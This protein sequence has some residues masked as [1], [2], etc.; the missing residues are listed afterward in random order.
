MIAPQDAGAVGLAPFPAAA[1]LQP[2]TESEFRLIRDFVHREAGIFLGPHKMAL[3]SS[4]LA[5]RLRELGFRR[6]GDYFRQAVLPSPEEQVHLLDRLCTHETRFFREPRQFELLEREILP[7]WR[8]AGETGGRPRRVRFWSA[9][10]STG[11]EP[12]SLALTLAA[13]LP[14]WDSQILATD[15]STRALARAE[16]ATWPVERAREIPPALLKRYLLRGT[17]SQEGL[18]RAGAELRARVR[19][20]RLNLNADSYP[21]EGG[22]DAIFCRNVL[23]YFD[24]ESKARVIERLVERLAPGGY[25]FLGHSESLIG[26]SGRMRVVQP[27]V[28]Q[29]AAGPPGGF[30]A[31][32]P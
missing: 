12:F 17:R 2:L 29:L 19:F 20:R 18:M 1:A 10:C 23:I 24:A 8:A 7:A 4:R 22:L 13:G 9:G 27:T 11:E 28:Y 30:P 31:S 21:V 15:L 5:R 25:L 32:R 16:A 3:L 6:Y 26:W 14:G